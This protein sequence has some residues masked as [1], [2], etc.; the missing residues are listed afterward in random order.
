M[1]PDLHWT[2][3]VLSGLLYGSLLLLLFIVTVRLVLGAA[4]GPA[5]RRSQL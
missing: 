5:A 1:V 2:I 4:D 3:D